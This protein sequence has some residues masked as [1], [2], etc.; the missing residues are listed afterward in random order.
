M[1]AKGEK[2]LTSRTGVKE[3]REKSE[4]KALANES[5]EKSSKNFEKGLDKNPKVWYN[6]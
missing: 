3:L 4:P 6:K 5:E 1:K 2:T